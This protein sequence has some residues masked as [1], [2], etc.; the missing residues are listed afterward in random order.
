MVESLPWIGAAVALP[1]QHG[2]TM[3]KS[4]TDDEFTT[5]Q[6]PNPQGKAADT[7]HVSRRS[8]LTTDRGKTGDLRR[9]C[10]W[11]RPPLFSLSIFVCGV[12]AVV[13]LR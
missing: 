9:D 11:Q 5:P 2:G 3:A 6:L 12:A 4:N 13:M 8:S 1:T 7:T 10:P